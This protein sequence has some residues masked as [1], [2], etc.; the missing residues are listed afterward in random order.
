[1]FSESAVTAILFVCADTVI[2]IAIMH[3]TD[4]ILLVFIFCVRVKGL[5]VNILSA[6]PAF[7]AM[8]GKWRTA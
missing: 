2:A 6:F 4:S 5:I 8:Q 3:I 1:M 7:L